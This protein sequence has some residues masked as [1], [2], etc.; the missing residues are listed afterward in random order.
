[1]SAYSYRRYQIMHAF[2][3][4]GWSALVLALLAMP[5]PAVAQQMTCAQALTATAHTGYTRDQIAE[6]WNVLVGCGDA[7]PPAIAAAIRSAPLNS[8]KDTL[9]LLAAWS[10]ADRRLVDSIIVLAKDPSQN[11][12]HGVC[13]LAY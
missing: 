9:A 6:A 8:A 3:R 10:L 7:A 5:A 2:K 11:V 1:V 12:T 13:S 4:L